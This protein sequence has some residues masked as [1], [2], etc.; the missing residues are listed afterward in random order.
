MS[1]S[2]THSLLETVANTLTGYVISVAISVHLYPVFGH[3]FTLAQNMAL[4]SIFTVVSILR[5]YAFRRAFNYL[6]LRRL[7]A[8]Q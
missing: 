1:Q 6:H 2:R 8:T 4:T 5:G 7:H 3:K